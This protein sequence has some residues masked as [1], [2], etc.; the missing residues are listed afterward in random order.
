MSDE[1]GVN[2]LASGG[3]VVPQRMIEQKKKLTATPAALTGTVNSVRSSNPTLI[4]L[5]SYKRVKVLRTSHQNIKLPI[6]KKVPPH[7]LLIPPV[8]G[9]GFRLPCA[10]CR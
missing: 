8:G 6:F 7:P 1:P 4:Q 5:I 10:S 9:R 2:G 3:C